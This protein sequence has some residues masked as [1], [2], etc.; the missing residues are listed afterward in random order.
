MLPTVRA[1]LRLERDGAARGDGHGSALGHAL[2]DAEVDRAGPLDGDVPFWAVVY[3]CLRCGARAEA[4]AVPRGRRANCARMGRGA[5]KR[6][7]QLDG[8]RRDSRVDGLG[9]AGDC[10]RRGKARRGGQGAGAAGPRDIH[11]F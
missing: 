2:L 6:R 5:G 10:G 4:R 3:Y 11:R 1:W 8:A 7:L 9:G